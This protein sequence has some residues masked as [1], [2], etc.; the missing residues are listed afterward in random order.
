MWG[1]VGL[2]VLVL[3]LVVL[4]FIGIGHVGSPGKSG[5]P[6]L[7]YLATVALRLVVAGS[8]CMIRVVEGVVLF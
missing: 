2:S 8:G 7:R 5:V 1:F 4:N 6:S 3:G